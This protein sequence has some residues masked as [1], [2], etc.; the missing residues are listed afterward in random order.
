VDARKTVKAK[1]LVI[2]KEKGNNPRM[3]DKKIIP[4][5]KNKE[6]KYCW[7]CIY[8]FSFTIEQT[9]WYVVY[10]PYSYVLSRREL[11][12]Y[13]LTKKIESTATKRKAKLLNP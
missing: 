7:R 5:K 3:L 2:V 13:R 10:T 4:N 8:K 11:K 12:R 1:E 6:E 9:S